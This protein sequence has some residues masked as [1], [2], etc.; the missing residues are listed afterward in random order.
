MARCQPA[1]ANVTLGIGR[2]LEQKATS[3]L[4]ANLNGKAL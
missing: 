2:K 4:P 3:G 1:G